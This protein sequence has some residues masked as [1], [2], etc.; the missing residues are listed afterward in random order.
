M[1]DGDLRAP[2]AGVD[3]VG[4]DDVYERLCSADPAALGV[5]E[6]E[7]L[8]Q[9]A[10]W[11][12]KPE[13]SLD[14]RRHAYMAHKLAGAEE[15]AAKA[16]WLLFIG[17]FDLGEIAV[18]GGWVKR[19]QQHSAAAPDTAGAGYAALAEAE[20]ARNQGDLEEALAHTDRA[21]E[22]GTASVDPDLVAIAQA[23]RGRILV[24]GGRITGGVEALDEAMV[25]VVGE[26]LSRFITGRV[27]CLLV[28]TCHELGDVSRAGEWTAAA[29]KWCEE[30]GGDSWYPGL[31]R[32]HRCELES[33][34]GEWM[35]AERQALRAVE[36]LVPFGDYWVGEGLYLVGEIRRHKGDSAGAEEA[37][38]QAHQLGRDPLPGLAL[39][40]AEKGDA[41]GA[42]KTLQ[43]ALVPGNGTP[44]RRAR[45][46]AAHATVA[47]QAE[48]VEDAEMSS[49]EL[50]ELAESTGVML[51][52]GL[53]ARARGAAL[54]AH[55]QPEEALNALR[56]SCQILRDLSIPYEEA[57]ARLLVGVASREAGDEA[58][59]DLELSAAA[60]TFGKLGATLDAERAS[61][62]LNRQ[63]VLPRGLTERE[64]EV[65]ALVAEGLTNREI[66][67][68]L[69]ISEHTVARHLSNVFRKLDVTSRSA[70]ATFALEHDL[71]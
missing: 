14:A 3:T 33:L 37:Y 65:L 16:A 60:A 40:R 59:A 39:L 9:A 43:L 10:F 32:L 11:L 4:W 42:L 35:L 13:E 8:A 50:E 17:H 61:A 51:L 22:L 55:D 48:A 15:E 67:E 34:R 5:D 70:A 26:E 69:F 20:W 12:G 2:A 49:R 66:A 1:T 58:T 36:E 63:K 18:A 38:E 71:T 68:S 44:L 6:L 19:S 28:S 24:D 62:L 21:I 53:A 25:A 52:Q 31:C 56:I 30:L 57:H 47:L 64:V 23:T 54:I 7:V 27:Y 46:L 45:L 29:A 41:D